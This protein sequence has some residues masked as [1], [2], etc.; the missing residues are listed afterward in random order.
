MCCSIC[1]CCSCHS[2][3]FVFMYCEF[4]CIRFSCCRCYLGTINRLSVLLSNNGCCFNG[5]RWFLS[6]SSLL[7]HC[8]GSQGSLPL[9]AVL[10][11]IDATAVDFNNWAASILRLCLNEKLLD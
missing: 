7:R 9:Y 11:D 5:C 6:R 2:K 3:I 8:Q 4:Y 1:T 10:D